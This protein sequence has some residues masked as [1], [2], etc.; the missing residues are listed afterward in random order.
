MWSQVGLKKRYY[1]AS[2]SDGISWVIS[3]PKRWCYESAA[4]NMAA[5]LE[6]L[7]S[8]HRTEKGQFLF[9]SQRRAMPKNVQTV[10]L[11]IFHMLARRS[12]ILQ[13]R[14]QQYMN[15]ELSVVQ[16]GFRKGRG[17]RG[18]IA[19]IRWITEK[20]RESQKNTCFCL[21]D[22]T[23]AFDCV[24]HN[25]GKFFKRWE[26]QTTLPV[27]W[28]ICLPVKKQQWKQ[29]WNNGLVPNWERSTSRLYIV[30][31]II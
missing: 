3:N 6:K 11:H 27:S 21:I 2:G 15:W 31:L 12:N 20:A 4:L 18:Q 19:N 13:V 16:A 24:Y 30:T 8:G 14:L 10:Q 25:C 26:Y 22:Y 17:T 7:S 1:K 23:K 29:T 28:E 5:N 9:Q